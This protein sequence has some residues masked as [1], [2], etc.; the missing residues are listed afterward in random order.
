MI[1]V[2]CTN[3]LIIIVKNDI[4]IYHIILSLIYVY[5]KYWMIPYHYKVYK[6]CKI[7]TSAKKFKI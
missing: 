2:K 6:H 7:V 4:I 5:Y 3:C 1:S